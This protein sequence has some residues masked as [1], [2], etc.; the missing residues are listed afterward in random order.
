[1]ELAK[2]PAAFSA[3]SLSS[4]FSLVSWNAEGDDEDSLKWVEGTA[5]DSVGV[6]R[7]EDVSGAGVRASPN[8]AW[9]FLFRMAPPGPVDTSSSEDIV[10]TPSLGALRCFLP[11]RL[12]DTGDG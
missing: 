3:A 10:N 7:G 1:M 9:T 12:G 2:Y 4:C 11:P 6:T 8:R 5:R